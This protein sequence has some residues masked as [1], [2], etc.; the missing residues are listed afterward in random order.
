MEEEKG[1]RSLR[2]DDSIIVVSADKGGATVIMDKNNYVNKAN[3]AFNYR[4]AYTLISEDPTKKQAA[5]IKKKRIH[6]LNVSPD[7]C[8]LSF[9]VVAVF[10]SRPHN[11][12]IESIARRLEETPIGIPTEHVLYMLGLCLKNYCQFDGK[13]YQQVK[14]TPMGSPISGL[15][16]ELVL[17][18]LEEV[19]IEVI[20][21]KMWLRYVD[22]TFV[23][24]KNCE[25]KR[26]H[27]SLNGVFPAIQFTREEATG[28]ILPFL[29]VSVQ[30]LTDGNLA[31]SVHRKD[32][33]A[34]IIL[35]Y[36]SNLPAARKKSCV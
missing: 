28:D 34:E 8:I 29:D 11:L 14:S 23:V 3:Q 20:R 22:D 18:R 19:V 25:V 21:P 1:L 31:A 30:R 36:E 27:Q 16:A 13:Y 24:I 26:L 5:S 17:Q 33:S 2:S 15:L 9:D 6:G 7:E 35:K 12:A 32:S 10:S 4:E